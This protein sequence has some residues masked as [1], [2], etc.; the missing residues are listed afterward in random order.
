MPRLFRNISALLVSASLAG[1]VLGSSAVA[2]S[3]GQRALDRGSRVHPLL[4]VG[5]Q[6]EPDKLVQVLVSKTGA[7]KSSRD[8]AAA[9]HGRIV[10]EFST[11]N[12]MVLEVPQSAAA[13]LDRIPGV[14]AIAL[15]A[16]LT[17]NSVDTTNLKNNY[18]G[19]I[20]TQSVWNGANALDGTGITVAIIDTGITAALP[21]FGN[22][23]VCIDLSPA[24]SGCGDQNGHG[25]HVAGIVAGRDPLGRYI[26]VAPGVR[27][28]SVKVTDNQGNATAKD[29]MRG[30]QWVYDNRAAYKIRVANVSMGSSVAE[31]YTTSAVDAYVEQLWLNGVVVVAS[32]GNRGTASDATWFAPANDPFAVTVGALDENLSAITYDDGLA[33]YSS[34]G[35]TQDGFRKPDLIA[36]G[37]KIPSTSAGPNSLM[38]SAHPERIVDS[39]YIRSSG[40]SMAAPIVTGSIALLLQK[41]P[42]LTPNQVKWLLQS[43]TS[44]YSAQS[45][46]AGIVT[47]LMLLQK[48]ASGVL[49]SAN[50]GLVPQA[51]ITTSTGAVSTSSYWNQ[52]YW[53]QSYWN[54]TYWN[55]EANVY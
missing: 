13:T 24:R 26:G 40:T 16:P 2:A 14:G 53:N 31:S 36:P 47:P 32:A 15:D 4:Q 54:Q 7:N 29:L 39:T 23:V 50:Q 19:T 46:A 33:A 34:R 51:S 6:T 22:R 21:D 35:N 43:T 27:I 8:I 18:E 11:V 48:A 28:I 12:T 5:A 41:Y 42:N 17:V 3:P 30:L 45:D 49:S 1:V 25:T 20:G 44:G 9:A 55:Q 52:S 37:R 38:A 10:E